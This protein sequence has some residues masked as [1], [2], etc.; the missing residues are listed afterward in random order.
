MSYLL[1][2]LSVVAEFSKDD[3]NNVSHSTCSSYDETL[4]LLPSRGEL[5]SRQGQKRHYVT[6]MS[7]K[8]NTVSSWLPLLG[9][10]PLGLAML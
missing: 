7:L 9:Y 5:E 3:L 2:E 1:F 4:T 8:G 6:S 10:L